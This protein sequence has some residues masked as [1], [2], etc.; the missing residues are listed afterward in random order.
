MKN[1]NGAGGITREGRDEGEPA[2]KVGV[3]SQGGEIT[4]FEDRPAEKVSQGAGMPDD[5]RAEC[6]AGIQMVKKGGDGSA[7]VRRSQV[8]VG[9]HLTGLRGRKVGHG[10]R[11]GR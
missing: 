5:E 7:I 2:G 10:K 6:K 4:T 1:E 9:I 3:G 8:H 11:G